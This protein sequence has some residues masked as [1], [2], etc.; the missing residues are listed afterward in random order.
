MSRIVALVC[1][2]LTVGAFVIQSHAADARDEL[3][4]F[5]DGR[6]VADISDSGP[7]ANIQKSLETEA[8]KE[9]LR[10]CK[11]LYEIAAL[12]KKAQKIDRAGSAY[13]NIQ[14]KL[15]KYSIP[16]VQDDSNLTS[17][18]NVDIDGDGI[19]DSIERSCG[20][21]TGMLCTIFIKLSTGQDLDAGERAGASYLVHL[22]DRVYLINQIYGDISSY[23]NEDTTSFFLITSRNVQPICS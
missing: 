18:K 19:F 16:M 6:R 13:K 7:V 22:A 20:T 5:T 4:T 10:T 17:F 15:K 11:K 21:G 3:N 23:T 1:L 14:E 2:M 8:A 12:H 9:R